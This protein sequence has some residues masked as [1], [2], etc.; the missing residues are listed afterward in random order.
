KTKKEEN[1]GFVPESMRPEQWKM[2]ILYF[3]GGSCL[4]GYFFENFT[5][6]SLPWLDSSLTMASLIAQWM[7]AKKKIENW[8]LWIIADSVYI[9]LFLLKNLPLT[10]LL[11][12]LFL[13][14]AV[15]G[16]LK[17]RKLMPVKTP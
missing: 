12:L 15:M 9:P 2:T 3:L 13:L 17:W 1:T 11:Y 16:L 8:V 7:I 4:L 5:N 10:A 6:A 14:M